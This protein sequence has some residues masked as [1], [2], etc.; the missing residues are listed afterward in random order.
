AAMRV[1]GAVKL[2]TRAT[3]L[4]GVE[5]LLEHRA[6]MEGPDTLTPRNLLRVSVGVEH[7]DDLIADLEQAL[8]KA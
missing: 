2:F 5:S 7:A 6:S 4:G 1:A 8:G 3:S